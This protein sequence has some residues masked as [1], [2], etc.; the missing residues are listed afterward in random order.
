MKK[1]FKIGIFMGS[2]DPVHNGHRKVVE[3]ALNEVERV[4]IMPAYQ[5]PFKN[6]SAPFS[7]RVDMLKI[8]FA[9]LIE[10]GKVDIDVM[11]DAIAT[12]LNIDKVPSWL[13]LSNFRN[14]NGEDLA[15]ITT[16][17]TIKEMNRWY[18]P[19][20]GYDFYGSF[21]YIVYAINRREMTLDKE[22][23][24]LYPNIVKTENGGYVH[25]ELINLL[26]YERTP[27][28]SQ[29]RKGSY[30]FRKEHLHEGVLEYIYN[31]G[32]Y[33]VGRNWCYTIEDGEH[34]GKTLYSGCYCA[35]AGIVYTYFKAYNH[36]KPILHFLANKRGEG[37]PDYNGYWN[38]TCGFKE[39]NENGKEA[40]AREVREE[41][42]ISIDPNLFVQ[43]YV[44][45]EPAF[46]NN[47]NVTIR[48][49]AELKEEDIPLGFDA[50]SGEKDEV[51]DVKWI[52]YDEID[53]Y[54]WAFNHYD[55][56]CEFIE[57]LNEKDKKNETD[58]T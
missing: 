9:D 14:N 53:K 40:I 38:L 55:I 47:G 35:V 13:T 52:A 2:F 42:G 41:C 33:E 28:S 56:L 25:H 17:E 43:H 21:N 54:P 3:Q 10:E 44:E 16:V 50:P 24:S 34:K 30:S 37:C 4:F 22:T 45:T 49:R 39:Q 12:G 23:I 46:C 1:K 48:Y 31:H 51:A 29:I 36:G 5:N 57:W 6:N 11:E 15:V 18:K 20:F 26:H 58:N 32:L 8:A 19:E 7:M 27:H